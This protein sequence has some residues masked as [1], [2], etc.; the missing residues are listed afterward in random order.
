MNETDIFQPCRWTKQFSYIS[1]ELFSV[2]SKDIFS[3][4]EVSKD[5][6]LII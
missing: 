4:S 3:L 5:E 6:I 1:T 2:P